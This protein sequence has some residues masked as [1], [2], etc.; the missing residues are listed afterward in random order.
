M[1]DP[2]RQLLEN[3]KAYKRK[4]VRLPVAKA[5]KFK[6]LI[7][8]LVLTDDEM[9]DALIASYFEQQ[10]GVSPVQAKARVPKKFMP[11]FEDDNDFFF[12]V[13]DLYKERIG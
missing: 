4:I 1:T 8:L 9:I 5:A 13:S 3:R 12:Y 10:V 7:K 11:K 6:D 2:F